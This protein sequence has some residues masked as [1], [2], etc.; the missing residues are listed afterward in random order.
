MRAGRL[1]TGNRWEHGRLHRDGEE[2]EGLLFSGVSGVPVIY[3]GLLNEQ[4]PQAR[5]GI[6]IG[7]WGGE[8]SLELFFFFFWLRIEK[9]AGR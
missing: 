4:V 8:G 2:G 9:M 5:H 3:L 7:G 6:I 1:G